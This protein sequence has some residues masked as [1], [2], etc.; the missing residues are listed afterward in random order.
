V[1]RYLLMKDGWNNRLKQ[2]TE[3]PCLRINNI[4]KE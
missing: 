2:L 4:K 3:I 1:P